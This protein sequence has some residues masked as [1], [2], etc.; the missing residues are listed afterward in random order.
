MTKRNLLILST[1]E[2][3]DFGVDIGVSQLDFVLR[4]LV[5]VF[6]VTDDIAGS[7]GAFR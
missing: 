2:E 6:N 3:I 5:Q 4:R 1:T 7:H